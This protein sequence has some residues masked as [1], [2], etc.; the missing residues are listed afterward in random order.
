MEVNWNEKTGKRVIL[1]MMLRHTNSYVWKI[2]KM[3]KKILLLND[4]SNYKISLFIHFMLFIKI[5]SLTHQRK[6]KFRLNPS[7]D[8]EMENGNAFVFAH[9]CDINIFCLFL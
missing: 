8:E 9:F 1:A 4:R 6:K 5:R 7:E 2:L 3:R